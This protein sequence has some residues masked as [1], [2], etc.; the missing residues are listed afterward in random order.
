MRHELLPTMGYV[1]RYA[2]RPPISEVRIKHYDKETVSFEYKDY[3]NKGQPVLYT[4]PVL[5]FIARLIQH[6]PPHYFN[7]IRHY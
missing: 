7:T 4:L 5:N 3:Y 2:R 6:I 1:A